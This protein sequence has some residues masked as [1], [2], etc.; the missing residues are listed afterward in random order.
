MLKGRH[1]GLPMAIDRAVLLPGQELM[2]RL[3]KEYYGTGDHKHRA[4]EEEKIRREETGSQA[5]NAEKGQDP[6]QDLESEEKTYHDPS[7]GS[8]SQTS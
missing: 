4:G 5:E 6:E 1:R 2:E 8:Y 7:E 3:D